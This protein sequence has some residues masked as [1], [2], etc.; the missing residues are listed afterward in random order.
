[1]TD[2]NVQVSL[3]ADAYLDLGRQSRVVIGAAYEAIE[4]LRMDPHHPGLGLKPLTSFG[5]VFIFKLNAEYRAVV[6]ALAQDQFLILCADHRRN[7]E[8][9][10]A[11]AQQW[12]ETVL[13]DGHDE[14]AAAGAPTRLATRMT[15]VASKL[16]GSGRAHLQDEWAAVLAGDPEVNTTLTPRQQRMFAFGFVLAAIR[17]RV[18]DSVRPLWWPVDWFLRAP[19]RTNAFIAMVVGGQA[20]F[21]VG[22]DGLTALL[23]EVWEPCGI[24]GASL[25]ALARWLRRVRGIEL[26]TSER[27]RADD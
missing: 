9:F 5:S 16:A 4:R 20:I 8:R 11:V 15:A 27:E 22:D 23:T 6:V 13:V 26:A 12:I 7:Y 3:T 17:L 14:E 1:M 10:S 2:S 19:S 18:G 25:F 21:I 24:A